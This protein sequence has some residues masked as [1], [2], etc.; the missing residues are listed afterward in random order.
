MLD[1]EARLTGAQAARLLGVTRQA[2]YMWRGRGHLAA[3]NDGL[4]RLGD[5]LAANGRMRRTPQ[6][7]RRLV[8][9]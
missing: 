1:P 2:V 7:H 6:S 5:V 4:Y 8:A 3:D 9:A